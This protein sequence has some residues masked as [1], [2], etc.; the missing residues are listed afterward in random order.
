[1]W[2]PGGER[3]AVPMCV[4]RH[5]KLHGF[6]RLER[7]NRW[8]HTSLGLWRLHLSA[9]SHVER[10][11]WYVLRNKWVSVNYGKDLYID[12]VAG[13]LMQ[14]KRGHTRYKR[15]K[16]HIPAPNYP[17]CIYRRHWSIPDPAPWLAERP[18]R[19]W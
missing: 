19:R 4:L 6:C 16:Y 17:A 5:V 15:G 3:Y 9:F 12:F 8:H 18:G 1:M 11:K 10:I 13:S 2:W 7:L 14:R